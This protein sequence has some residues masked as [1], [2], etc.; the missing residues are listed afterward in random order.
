M[1]TTYG[2]PKALFTIIAITI[3][4]LMA[5]WVFSGCAAVYTEESPAIQKIDAIM[6]DAVEIGEVIESVLDNPTA[7]DV[8]EQLEWASLLAVTT[9]A[10]AD[11]LRADLLAED[12][13]KI[14]INI[15]EDTEQPSDSDPNT[16]ELDIKPP[17]DQA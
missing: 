13:T 1:K 6:E 15:E 4:V 12:S 3:F 14:K 5:V 11:S 7:E 9:V 17:K 10:L 16:W 8:T 2:L